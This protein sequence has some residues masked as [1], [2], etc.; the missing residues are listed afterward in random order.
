MQI[1][2]DLALRDSLEPVCKAV[3]I[4]KK[5]ALNY[6]ADWLASGVWWR[7]FEEFPEYIDPKYL[8]T[9]K[10]SYIWDIGILEIKEEV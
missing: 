5:E 9:E 6:P 8:G 4:L 1:K 10:Y 7:L 2:L 3:N